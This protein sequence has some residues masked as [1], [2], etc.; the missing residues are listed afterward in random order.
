[1]LRFAHQKW[2]DDTI[3]AR[4]RSLMS[5]VRCIPLLRLP[6]ASARAD[7]RIL[8]SGGED[9]LLVLW[10]ASDGW[11]VSNNSAAHQ[12]KRPDGHYGKLPAGVLSVAFSASG[13]L[14]S[15]GRDKQ[16]K[17]WNAEG[18]AVESSAFPQIPLHCA[19]APDGR[20]MV[21]GGAQGVVSVFSVPTR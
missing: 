15:A 19:Y 17:R 9:G 1:M 18:K 4:V 20:S 13:E 16:V 12:P 14:L 8:A 10:D 11:P 2:C 5:A 7:G 21:I 3:D 6:P